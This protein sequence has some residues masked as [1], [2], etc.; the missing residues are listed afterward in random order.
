[1]GYPSS[2]YRNTVTVTSQI[3]TG[4]SYRY[5]VV[6]H[7]FGNLTTQKRSKEFPVQTIEVE[8]KKRIV[9]K[10]GGD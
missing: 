10:C 6:L 8:L 9:R 4:S 5:D 1:M 2:N 3:A 7:P